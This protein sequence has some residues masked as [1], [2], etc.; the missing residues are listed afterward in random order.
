V[1]ARPGQESDAAQGNTER[2]GIARQ[3]QF[4]RCACAGD[5]P[6]PARAVPQVTALSVRGRHPGGI[7]TEQVNARL[8]HRCRDGIRSGGRMGGFGTIC[9]LRSSGYL[10]KPH[11]EALQRARPAS[12]SI[13][14]CQ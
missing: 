4:I 14:P 6:H 3:A 13:S 8:C 11:S 5:D 1:P 7:E 9:R 12:S 2:P 10:G